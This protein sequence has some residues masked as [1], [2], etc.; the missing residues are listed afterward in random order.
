MNASGRTAR[1]AALTLLARRARTTKDLEQ[2]LERKGFQAAQVVAALSDLVRL[3]LVDDLTFARAWAR[4]QAERRLLGPRAVRD[5]LI[6][7]GVTTAMANDVVHELYTD[8]DERRLARKV[9]D[10]AGAIA[11]YA[12]RQRLRARLARRGFSSDAIRVAVQ[13]AADDCEDEGP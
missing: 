7:Q 9:A 1:A 10:R 2:R 13:S 4:G 11:D 8:L 5:G 12:T 3:G 6:R